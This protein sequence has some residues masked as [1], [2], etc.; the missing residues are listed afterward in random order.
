MRHPFVV[1][2]RNAA[3]V[4]ALG[5]AHRTALA[6]APPSADPE[7]PPGFA[8]VALADDAGVRFVS[9]PVRFGVRYDGPVPRTVLSVGGVAELPETITLVLGP[10]RPSAPLPDTL[11]ALSERGLDGAAVAALLIADREAQLTMLVDPET[12]RAALAAGRMP[13]LDAVEASLPPEVVDDLRYLRERH[14]A[15]ARSHTAVIH[16]LDGAADAMRV[17][18]GGAAAG[19]RVGHGGVGAV[20]LR[21]DVPDP[22]GDAGAEVA[23]DAGPRYAGEFWGQ[24]DRAGDELWIEGRFAGVAF[25]LPPHPWFRTSAQPWDADAVR[26]HDASFE[27]LWPEPFEALAVSVTPSGAWNTLAHQLRVE[28]LL[29]DGRWT[30]FGSTALPPPSTATP[31]A[32][33]ALADD[34]DTVAFLTAHGLTT[35]QFETLVGRG[36]GPL[37]LRSWQAQGV[38]RDDVPG[39][40]LARIETAAE[41]ATTTPA[42]AEPGDWREIAPTLAGPPVLALTLPAGTRA[43]GVRFVLHG[44]PITGEPW[45]LEVETVTVGPSDAAMTHHWRYDHAW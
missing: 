6:A 27:A 34:R 3:L 32:G 45:V 9:V 40:V 30:L 7:P 13:D 17:G 44:P 28:L 5:V 37:L 35:T 19:E 29:A 16:L 33:P 36:Q 41:P 22:D 38:G 4:A 8:H 12:L 24:V 23:P 20:E 1:A 2:V 43:Q 31:T 42:P 11:D 10:G 39:V 18:H 14:E 21:F 25:D 15:G 26:P